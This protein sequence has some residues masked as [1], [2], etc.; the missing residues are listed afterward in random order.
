MLRSQSYAQLCEGGN[1]GRTLTAYSMQLLFGEQ[2]LH[3]HGSHPYIQLCGGGGGSK[4]LTAH[5]Y[6]LDVVMAHRSRALCILCACR[7]R[8][9]GLLC[10]SWLIR[11]VGSV[12]LCVQ[13]AADAQ[14]AVPVL[15][16]RVARMTNLRF[17]LLSHAVPM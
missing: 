2:A 7:F 12:V 6:L 14:S 8:V 16:F 9:E 4:M 1:V 13:K 10:F 5:S 11:A 3:V 15:A 17:V